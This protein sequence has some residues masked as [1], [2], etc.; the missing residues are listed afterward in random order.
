MSTPPVAIRIPFPESAELSLRLTV[1]AC[2]LTIRPGDGPD[3]VDGTYDDPSN[4]L[5]LRIDQEGGAVRI[6]QNVTWPENWGRVNRPP[7]FEL[8][9]G[10]G[11][12]Y[13]LTL[14]VGANEGSI[15]LGGL[16]LTRL[17]IHHGAGKMSIGFSAP[18]PQTMAQ[19]LATAGAAA[20]DITGL[21]HAGFVEMT[22]E[23]GAASY[24]FDFSGALV[25]D[26]KVRISTG[27]SAIVL[28]VPAGTAARIGAHTVLGSVD[29]GDGFMKKEGSFWNEAALAGQT[30]ALSI[31]ASVAMGSIRLE[32]T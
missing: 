18:N 9:L 22:V 26:G 15:D 20:L 10:K 32:V 25:R 19:L 2:R 21:A 12:P 31:D 8:A 24:S 11:R 17:T 7:A 29:L 4:A 13:A 27:M 23:G 30:P 3:W 5:P 28:R 14:E 1:G 16:P 6:G